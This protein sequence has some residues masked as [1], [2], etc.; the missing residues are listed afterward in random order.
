[1]EKLVEKGLVKSIGLSNFNSV[2][3]QDVLEKGK[4]IRNI[5]NPPLSCTVFHD[6]KSSGKKFPNE[7]YWYSSTWITTKPNKNLAI[8]NQ[9]LIGL[10]S[11]TTAQI[12]RFHG[13][14]MFWNEFRIHKISKFGLFVNE[15]KPIKF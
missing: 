12:M 9:N 1:M 7:K 10:I 14:I 13:L 3:I 4:V 6:E 5:Q 15:I 8:V 11:S 2:Q